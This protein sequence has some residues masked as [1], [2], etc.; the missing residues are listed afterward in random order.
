ML[1]DRDYMRRRGREGTDPESGGMRCLFIL[2]VANVLAEQCCEGAI[3]GSCK[4]KTFVKWL[5]RL[6]ELDEE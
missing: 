5:N 3:L 6:K 1:D 2:I 4:D